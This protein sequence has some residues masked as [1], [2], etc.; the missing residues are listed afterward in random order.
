MAF[1]LA[2]K[3]EKPLILFPNFIPIE[4]RK[5]TKRVERS[6]LIVINKVAYSIEFFST[7]RLLGTI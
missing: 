7:T 5:T 2:N 1:Y 6:S 4:D 3:M